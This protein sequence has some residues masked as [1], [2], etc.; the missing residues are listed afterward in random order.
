MGCAGTGTFN[1]SGGTNNF[2]GG[3]L[4]GLGQVGSTGSWDNY[5]GALFLGYD[6]T[7]NS[8]NQGKAPSLGTYNL[9]GGVLN[10]G[11]SSNGR[12]DEYIGFSGTGVFNQTGGI[13]TCNGVLDVGGCSQSLYTS[14]STGNGTYNLSAGLLSANPMG[15]YVGDTGSGLINQTGGTNSTYTVTLGGGVSGA[16]SLNGGLLQTNAINDAGG[17]VFTFTAGTLQAGTGWY[18]TVS[19]AL[20]I[21]VTG[22]SPARIDMNGQQV[23]LK[24][25]VINSGLTD[26]NFATPGVDLLTIGS[27]GLNVAANT[28]ISLG[29]ILSGATWTPTAGNYDLI[30][31]TIGAPA[32]TRHRN[33]RRS[34]PFRRP[35]LASTTRC[36]RLYIQAMSTWSWPCLNRELW[37]S[38]AL[39]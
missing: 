31:G 22:T 13:N 15:E 17:A 18:P 25:L 21:N 24:S 33:W 23:I 29:N 34:S 11:G 7:A 35:R 8:T 6:G 26:L 1:Q 12:S 14:K 5:E 36:R 28:Q 32:R 3:G 10:G 39:D 19:W 30:T 38:W 37:H 16:Y 20:P 27:G 9:S 2:N 4:Q